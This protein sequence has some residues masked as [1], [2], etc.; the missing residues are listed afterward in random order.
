MT[1]SEF[2][3]RYLSILKYLHHP[4]VQAK[5]SSG[6]L[7]VRG[8]Q[9]PL[10]VY[11]NQ[12]YDSEVPWNGLFRSNLLVWVTWFIIYFIIHVAY[13]VL[14]IQTHSYIAQLRGERKGYKIW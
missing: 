9:W 2:L 1:Q 13:S 4:R 6:E 11:A 7:V 14:G 3:R 8:D 5:L 12:E 10:L